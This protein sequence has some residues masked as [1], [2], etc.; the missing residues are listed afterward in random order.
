VDR[1]KTIEPTPKRGPGRPKKTPSTPAIIE[2]STS[3]A[4]TITSPNQTWDVQNFSLSINRP[5][6]TDHRVVAG[7]FDII[8][9]GNGEAVLPARVNDNGR[10]A[11]RQKQ[12]QQLLTIQFQGNVI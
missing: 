6:G 7:S 1:E 5:D 12:P 11:S 4:A 2:T 8:Y 10:R 3:G 9:S